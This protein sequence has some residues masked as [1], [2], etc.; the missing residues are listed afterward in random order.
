MALLRKCSLS[1]VTVLIFLLASPRP[2]G[3]YAVLTHEELI[4][5]TWRDSIQPLLLQ[6]FPSL[7]PAQLREAHAYAYG[8]CVIQD[9]GYYPFGKPLFSD[10]LHYVRTGDFIRALFRESKDADDVAFA[11]GALSH[12]FGDTIGHPEAVNLAVGKSF[13]ELAAKYGPNVNYAEGRHQHVRAEFA[14]DIN[15]ITKHRL[16][17]ERYL[18]H[19]GF[20]VPVPLLTRAFYDT[21]G[22]DLAKLLG[23]SHPKLRGYRYSVRSLLPRVA[24]AETLLHRSHMPPDV[25]SPALDQFTQQIAALAAAD[26]WDSY[27][28]H[29]G[30][31]THLLAGFIFILPKIGALSDLSVRGP[32]PS[33]EQDYVNSLMHTADVFRQTLAKATI[34]DGLPNKDLD[35]G[36]Y[37]RPG[38]YSLE[39]LTYVDLLHEMTRDPG[40][41]IP[42]GIKR[43]LV[44]YFADLSKVTYLNQKPQLRAQV[45]TDLPILKTISTK[46][47]YPDS[48]FLPEPDTAKA[49]D[50]Q[51]ESRDASPKPTKPISPSDPKGTAPALLPIPASATG[52]VA[53]KPQP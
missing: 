13:P 53:P 16:A 21:Y 35:T 24:Y 2:L 18:N 11:I 48:A 29:A 33:A 10:L 41:P 7:T 50:P 36:D 42:F 49:P 52:P 31:G 28:S 4:D 19:I 23:H 40:S 43:D 46:A 37:A 26:H 27:R 14:F 3:A 45:Q 12:Y 8:G 22:L 30:I 34:S 38:S 51:P 17:P 44:A 1:L 6:R 39:D 20:A 9:L 32:T 25:P 15:D 5:L 47:A